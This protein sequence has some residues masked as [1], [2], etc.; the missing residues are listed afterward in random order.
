MKEFLERMRWVCSVTTCLQF[1]TKFWRLLV[2]SEIWVGLEF[3]TARSENP[4]PLVISH[5]VGM[6]NIWDQNNKE[7]TTNLL[8]LE[9]KI[10]RN[11]APKK[12]DLSC[13]WEGSEKW[14]KTNWPDWGDLRTSSEP[15]LTMLTKR[16]N[17]L[18]KTR[19]FPSA[20]LK[21]F[22]Y[23]PS[24]RLFVGEELLSML[25]VPT[26]AGWARKGFK[27][28]LQGACGAEV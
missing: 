26:L 16:D 2:W 24:G 28:D 12:R 19:P 10:E 17:Q 25:S 15:V 14:Q 11:T 6:K 22:T 18:W 3:L 27:R 5:N 4:T 21:W 1:F 20:D 9:K 7:K 8:S 23:T 13:Y